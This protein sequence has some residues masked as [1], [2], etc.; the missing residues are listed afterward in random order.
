MCARERV[1]GQLAFARR[2]LGGKRERGRGF[3]HVCVCVRER[4]CLCE[5]E[6]VCEREGERTTGAHSMRTGRRVHHLFPGAP[7]LIDGGREVERE[8]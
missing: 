6:G 5:R 4:G 7:H 1:K 2:G 8:R 3:V